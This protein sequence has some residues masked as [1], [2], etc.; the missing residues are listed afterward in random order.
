MTDQQRLQ[1]LFRGEHPC[2]L[3][4]TMEED[5]AVQLV[6]SS[7]VDAGLDMMR[8]SISHA[9]RDG[10]VENG[11]AIADT[12]HPAAALYQ[13]STMNRSLIAVMLDLIGHLKDER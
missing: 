2:I 4:T 3:I 13:L 12:E 7:C 8:W 5:A 10:L 6:T 9:L 1:Q 11:V